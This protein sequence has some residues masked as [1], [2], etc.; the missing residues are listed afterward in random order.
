MA[1]GT[2]KGWVPNLVPAEG[3]FELFQNTAATDHVTIT[4]AGNAAGGAHLVWR[5]SAGTEQG[6]ITG[7]GKVVLKDSINLEF[8]SLSSGAGDITMTFDATRLQVTPSTANTVL[9]F[10]D[11]TAGLDVH[12]QSSFLG[13]GARTV[14]DASAGR[15]LLRQS[16]AAN[17]ALLNLLGKETTV[18]TV[19]TAPTT[20]LLKGDLFLIGSSA[21]MLRLG[22]CVS[23][24][25]NLVQYTRKFDLGAGSST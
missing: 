18:T 16:V 14:W 11:T 13:G 2:Q 9:R 17:R 4:S 6:L 20:G 25:T 19:T 12:L 24:A 1:T 10:G 5:T 21:T 8:G 3:D 22:C 15:L 23:T 7:T